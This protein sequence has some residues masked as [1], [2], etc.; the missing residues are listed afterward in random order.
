MFVGYGVASGAYDSYAGL[1]EAGL[2]GKIAIAF[3]Y[4]PQDAR[5]RSRWAKRPGGWTSAASLTNKAKLAVKHG[6]SALLVVNP[7][8]Q[9]RDARLRTA[10]Q[11]VLGPPVAIP[12]MHI[13]SGA[14]GKMLTLAGRDG[15]K[16]PARLQAL[17]DEILPRTPQEVSVFS[18]SPQSLWARSEKTVPIPGFKTVQQVEENVKAMEFG[19]LSDEQMKQVEEILG[20]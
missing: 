18:T 6:A 20:R 9:D 13:S 3:R 11:S 12:V 10:E 16:E 1:G 14:L 19:P 5:G 8:S 15:R 7:P 17:A 2:K 4:E